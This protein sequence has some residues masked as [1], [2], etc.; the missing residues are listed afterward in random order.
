[1]QLHM[2]WADWTVIGLYVVFAIVVGIRFAKRAE[3][4]V[5]QFFLSGRSLPW[6]IAGTSMVATTFAADT[7]LVVSGWVRDFGIWKNWLW[8]VYAISGV[9]GVFLFSR[10]WRRGAVMTKAELAELR[11]RGRDAA[12]LRGFLGLFHATVSNTIVLCWVLLAAAKIMDVLFEV[13]KVWA[14]TAACAVSLTYSLLAGFWGVVMTDMV[15]FAMAMVGAIV[16]AV[17]SWNAV[18][19]GDAIVEAALTSSSFN[20]DTLR[21]LPAWG[22]GGVFDASFWTVPF[23]AFAVYLG[24]AWWGA[25]S[26]DGSGVAVQRIL[27]SRDDRHGML[28]TLWYNIAHY[29]LRPW[30]WVCVALAS[31]LLLP[32]Q[33]V[34]SPVDGVVT[35]VTE[36]AVEVTD[37]AGVVH[38]LGLAVEDAPEAWS[39]VASVEAT[40]AVEAGMVVAATDSERAYVVMMTEF[41]PIGLLGLVV[42]SLLA[43]FMSTID[44]HVNLASSFFVN[45]VYRRFFVRDASPKNY[46]WAARLASVVILGIG[47]LLAYRASSISDLFLFFLALLSGVGPVYLM[48]WI[49]WRVRALTE[50]VAMVASFGATV[51]LT[52]LDSRFA[53]VWPESPLTPGGD[54][55][56]EGRLCLVVGFSLVCA[57][58]SVLLAPKP[59]PSTLVDF[60]RRVRPTGWWGPVRELAPDVAPVQE[61]TAALV[62]VISGLLAIYGPLFGTGCVLLGRYPEAGLAALVTGAGIVGIRWS[63]QQMTTGLTPEG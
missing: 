58:I 7:P 4:N 45:D 41:L 48:R 33:D 29:A 10:Y 11:Y 30:P 2:H 51:Y 60:Y 34:V 8:W 56:P 25:E 37:G 6:W 42:A 39:A 14:L 19:G 63:L 5:D 17:L 23:A 27:A 46:V 52:L 31:L 35:A 54:L 50:I 49:W 53:Y 9:L 3:E 28:A 44:T 22:E 32:H 20:P 1:M 43:A 18:G 47:G 55:A 12:A 21:F 36:T 15:Q 59:D 38:E 61:G 57:L 40:E 16:L 24:L 62:G 13:D 26:V